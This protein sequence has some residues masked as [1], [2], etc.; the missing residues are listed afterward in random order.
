[1]G[2]KIS[3]CKLFLISTISLA[4]VCSKIIVLFLLFGD[5]ILALADALA[6]CRP[7]RKNQRTANPTQTQIQ[8]KQKFFKSSFYN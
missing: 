3:R 4:F 1:M 5:T 2:L 8:I 7:H 6:H